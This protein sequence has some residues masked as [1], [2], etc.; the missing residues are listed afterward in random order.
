MA[1]R[2]LITR[3]TRR[4]FCHRPLLYQLKVDVK[5]WSAQFLF[6]FVSRALDGWLFTLKCINVVPCTCDQIHFINLIGITCTQLE[7]KLSISEEIHLCVVL[8]C[9]LPYRS[10]QSSELSTS[11]P[12]WTFFAVFVRG[13]REISVPLKRFLRAP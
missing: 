10:C 5:S 6:Q 8:C 7:E 1:N 13:Q 4:N 11:K 9:N 12:L 3:T 2:I